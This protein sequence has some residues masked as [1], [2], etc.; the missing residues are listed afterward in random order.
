MNR[1]KQYKL[2]PKNY[3]RP[4]AQR[5][6]DGLK[7]VLYSFHSFMGD[8]ILENRLVWEMRVLRKEV[9]ARAFVRYLEDK[10]VL[11]EVI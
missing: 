3:Y 4:T 5:N 9:E 1:K 8:A 10:G 11:I 6:I 7:S 2:N